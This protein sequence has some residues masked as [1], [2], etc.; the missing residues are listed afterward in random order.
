MNKDKYFANKGLKRNKKPLQ[1]KIIFVHVGISKENASEEMLKSMEM[2]KFK[3]IG[4]L[5][6]S[7]AYEK[8]YHKHSVKFYHG[9]ITSENLKL[10]LGEK[11][12]NKFCNGKREFIVQRRFNH[13]NI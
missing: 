10:K 1:N 11:Q 3:D 6:W 4:Y 12:W 8:L 13:K 2:Y 5:T 7:S 9:F